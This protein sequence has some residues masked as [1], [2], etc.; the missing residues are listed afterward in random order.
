MPTSTRFGSHGIEFEVLYASKALPVTAVYRLF[1]EEGLS[2]DVASGGE[3]ATALHAGF[4]PAR[5]Y[6]HGNNKTRGRDPD[7]GGGGGR[8]T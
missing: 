8:A 7:G 2:V 5:I 4:D 3:L 6:M 1:A